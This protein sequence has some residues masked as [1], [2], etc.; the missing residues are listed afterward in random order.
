ML[1]LE[2][3]DFFINKDSSEVVTSQEEVLFCAFT[4]SKLMISRAGG[5]VT[6]C[7][8][9]VVNI[10]CTSEEVIL[11]PV[12]LGQLDRCIFTSRESFKGFGIPASESPIFSIDKGFGT[13]WLLTC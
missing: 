13:L 1:L 3:V 5:V 12:L 7:L 11:A 8:S 9:L 4:F 2:F 10:S 6:L